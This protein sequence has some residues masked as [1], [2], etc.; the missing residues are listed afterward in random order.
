VKLAPNLHVVGSDI[1]A[2]Y[3]V[4]DETGV[5][6]IDAGLSGDWREL[7]DELKTMS[8]SPDDI[9]GVVLTHGDTDHL[10]V[11]ERLRTEHK[12]PIYIHDADAPLARGETRKQ[13][14]PWGRLRI[15][16]TLGFLWYALRRGGLKAHPVREV[17][18]LSGDGSLQLPGH[19]EIIHIPGHSPGSIAIHVPS[20]KALFVGDALTTRHVLTGIEGPQPA[21]F[22]LDSEKAFESLSRLENLDVDWVLPGHGPPWKGGAGELV[23]LVREAAR[24][25]SRS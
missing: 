12:V 2:C 17:I 20:V 9:R 18:G 1:V 10:G 25:S 23:R 6:M 21:P 3:L 4:E 14:P 7:V 16:T 24:P 19:P 13:N 5:T 22:T 11:A 8:R 15:K